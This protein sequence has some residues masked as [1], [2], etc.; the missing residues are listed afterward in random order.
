MEDPTFTRLYVGNL[1]YVAQPDDVTALFRGNNITVSNIDMSIDPFSGRNP[2]YCFANF[3]SPDEAERAMNEL[4]GQ[5]VLGRAVKIRLGHAKKPRLP[6]PE[7]RINNYKAGGHGSRRTNNPQSLGMSLLSASPN[8]K[9]LLIPS[10]PYSAFCKLRTHV[11]PLV[12]SR[13][14]RPMAEAV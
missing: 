2:S 1:P 10:R 6:R 11:R 12:P 5:E 8:S 7:P 4:N 3:A 13:C 14:S 9:N